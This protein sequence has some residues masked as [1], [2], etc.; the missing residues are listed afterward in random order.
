MKTTFLEFTNDLKGYT[1]YCKKTGNQIY[2]WEM[3]WNKMSPIQCFKR[4]DTKIIIKA[5]TI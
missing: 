3:Y 1:F 2:R 4:F 5:V